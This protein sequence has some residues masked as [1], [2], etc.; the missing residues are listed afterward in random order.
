MVPPPGL[1]RRLRARARPLVAAAAAVPGADRYRETFRARDHL[2]ILLLHV[3]AGG[4]SLRQTHAA[5]A[6]RGF[7]GLRLPAGVSLSQLARSS[8]SRPAAPFEALLADLVAR[9]RRSAARDPARAALAKV[10]A[11]D[12]SFVALS[13]K[14]A[15]WAV[16]EAHPAGVRVHA[17]LDLAG[18]IP[19]SLV[20]TGTDA[21]DAAAFDRRDLAELRGWTVVFDLGYT[22]H[23]RFVRLRAGGVS[24]LCRLHPQATWAAARPRPVDAAP[25][26]DGDV[27]EADETVDL[28]SPRSHRGAVV[29]GVRLV[30]YRTA[31]GEAHRLVTDR[32]D[33]AAADVVALYRRRWRIELFFRFLK[34]QLKAVRPFGR[35]EAAVRP[36]VL[37]CAA[38]ALLAML[39]DD[40]RGPAV[41]RVAFA[42]APGAVLLPRRRCGP[43]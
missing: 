22:G 8:T 19:S 34:R 25:T 11:V 43:G 38:A 32:H 29:R 9:A 23:A 12:S 30:A 40:A 1:G 16:H 3:L 14:L 10:Q 31:A 26:A 6:A 33:L 41:S 18:E 13:A 15:P 21:H 42:R 35:S 37:V 2:W 20:V 24:F 36:T 5:L 27:V 4:D 17:G 28:G 39:L 7:A